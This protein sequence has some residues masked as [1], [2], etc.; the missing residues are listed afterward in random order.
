MTDK[1]RPHLLRDDL[2]SF[3]H[4]LFYYTLRY[5]AVFPGEDGRV[6]LRRKMDEVFSGHR[7]RDSNGR[8]VGGFEKAQY[9]CSDGVFN[10]DILWAQL[11]P[12]PLCALL[13]D[14]RELFGAV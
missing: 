1:L 6:V 14:A 11:Q 7:W 13:D 10:R 12:K 8:V 2:E 9:L 3:V 5:R 4:V